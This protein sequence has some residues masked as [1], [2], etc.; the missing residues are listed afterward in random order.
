MSNEVTPMFLRPSKAAK[1]LDVGRS[2]IYAMI[3]SRH[4]RAVEVGGLLR[5]PMSEL[6]A[7]RDRQPVGEN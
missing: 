4:I 6:E 3:R 2:K 5:I 1:L 7:L